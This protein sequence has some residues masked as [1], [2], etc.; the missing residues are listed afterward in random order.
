VTLA[1]TAVAVAA[2]SG[3]N[4]MAATQDIEA[5]ARVLREHRR[6]IT[7]I[8]ARPAGAGFE[9]L[10]E[11]GAASEFVLVGESHQ[12]AETPRLFAALAVALRDHGYDAVALEIGP[13]TARHLVGRMRRGGLAEHR[14]SVARYPFT[15]PFFELRGEA[16]LLE[17][18]LRH[19]YEVWGLDQEFVGSGRYWLDRLAALAPDDA[20]G[21]LVAAWKQR[22]LAAVQHYQ[23]TESTE[24]VIF[25]T[26][27][28]EDFEEL[29]AAF[30]RPVDGGDGT[31]TEERDE[32]LAIVDALAASA[33][34]Y[35]LWRTENYENNRRR[36][37]YMNGNLVAGLQGWRE[38]H[39]GPAK[40]LLK[41]GGYHMGRGRS[42]ANQ[43]DL[44]NLAMQLATYRGGRSLHLFAT[45]L[46]MR[47]ADG[48]FSDWG[49]DE[50]VW[51]LIREQVDPE[52]PWTVFDLRPL[53]PYFHRAANQQGN[54]SIAGTVWNYDLVAIAPEF[55]PAE[56][57]VAT[58]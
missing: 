40:V 5:A 25:N 14:A 45:A 55:H 58:Q 22:E 35:Q 16:E 48:S 6:V 26:A 50:P 13:L 33:Q 11:E 10:V 52:Q 53:R 57:L 20:A 28:P 41:F 23:E 27:G 43:F 42:P 54:E 30:S 15:L 29:R 2:S 56:P 51:R 8:A 32:A 21:E 9:F 39:G 31:S 18:A 19:G 47:G 4:E 38:R 3:E 24:A 17:T 36:V 12:T 44:G 7:G 37:A 34:I 1:A 49:I 46:G